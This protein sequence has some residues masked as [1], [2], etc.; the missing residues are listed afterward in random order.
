MDGSETGL[1]SMELTALVVDL[2]RMLRVQLK[3]FVNTI[4]DVEFEQGQLMV[5][6]IKHSIIKRDKISTH[7]A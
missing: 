1:M 3:E 4:E 2:K 6:D 7:V 5:R